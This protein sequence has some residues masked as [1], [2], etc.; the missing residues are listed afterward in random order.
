MGFRSGGEGGLRVRKIVFEDG[1][2]AG[3][4]MRV[5]GITVDEY[6]E[7]ERFD[8]QVEL[9]AKRLVDWNWEDKEGNPIPP[10]RA[11]IATLDVADLRSAVGEWFL[12]IGRAHPR[13]LA[14]A[15]R[16]AMNGQLETTIPMGPSSGNES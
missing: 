9:F 7:T 10:T 2:M 12:R 6:L 13:P 11:G 15:V 14:P 3:L 4:E 16:A 8:Q 1:E 5:A